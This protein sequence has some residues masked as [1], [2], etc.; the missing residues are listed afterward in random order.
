MKIG[1]IGLG[2]VGSAVKAAYESC[3]IDIKYIL[4]DTD[5]SKGYCDTYEDWSRNECTTI[6]SR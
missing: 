3:G 6:C 2:F 5:T 4:M 1:I